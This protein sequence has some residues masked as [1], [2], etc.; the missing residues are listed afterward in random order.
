MAVP[1]LPEL[2]THRPFVRFW[3]ARLAGITANQMLMVAV[4]RQV[5]DLTSSVWDLGLV[6]LFKFVPARV[7]T[8][9]AR[10]PGGPVAPGRLFAA[11]MLGRT[12][13]AAAVSGPGAARP[14][15]VGPPGRR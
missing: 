11:C 5:Y 14:H 10:P 2:F 7:M 8:L 9:P 3:L 6:G 15:G 12:L 13:V 4:A 1:H